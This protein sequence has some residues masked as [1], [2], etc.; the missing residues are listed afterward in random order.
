MGV[1]QGLLQRP[2]PLCG[3]SVRAACLVVVLL[4]LVVLNASYWTHNDLLALLV[5]LGHVVGQVVPGGALH[6]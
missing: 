6:G 4:L 2:S 1:G 3:A 5:L